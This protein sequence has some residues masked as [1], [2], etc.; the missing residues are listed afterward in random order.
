MDPVIKFLG[1]S[2]QAICAD[3][4]GRVNGEF[5]I[6][7]EQL[8]HLHDDPILLFCFGLLFGWAEIRM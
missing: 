7:T 3:A 1:N 4:N 8:P 6:R 5:H 2:D